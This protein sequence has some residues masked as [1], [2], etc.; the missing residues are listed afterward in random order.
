MTEVTQ[1]HLRGILA[2]LSG[3]SIT[4]GFLLQFV[5]GSFLSWRKVALVNAAIPL[6][7]FIALCFIPETPTWLL[8]KNRSADAK[9]SLAWLRGWTTVQ[10]V[11]EEF[12][13]LSNSIKQH[14]TAEKNPSCRAPT[15]LLK[16]EVYR[17]M[18]LVIFTFLLVHF[19]GNAT[20]TVYAVP[21]FTA[22]KSPLNA[23]H[24]TVIM[25]L[26]HII[27]GVICACLINR[28]GKRIISFITLLGSCVCFAIVAICT[29]MY[30]I[31][32]INQ[33][34]DNTVLWIP[35]IFLQ[36]G[37]LISFSGIIY[38]PWTLV[39]DVFPKEYR[40]VG[41]GLCAGLGQIVGFVSNK[42]YLYMIFAFTLP[43]VFLFNSIIC[44]LGTIVLYFVLPET[45]G[46]SLDEILSHFKGETKLDNK[47]RH[48]KTRLRKGVV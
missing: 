32:Y 13:K 6:I 14:I 34:S 12:Q 44:F 35:V 27:G 17:P 20:L 21:I 22:L 7:G 48:S 16:K 30:D 37:T 40:A 31:L 25:G 24:T 47:V 29:Y 38:L 46:K 10:N 2:T 26:L 18:S 11:E 4:L 41:S 19:S 36:L 23:Y 9:K 15:F 42:T 33:K 1:P 5:V 3:F 43:G 28:L 39:G 8:L 45:E